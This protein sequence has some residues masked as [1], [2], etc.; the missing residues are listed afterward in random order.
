MSYYKEARYQMMI[1]SRKMVDAFNKADSVNASVDM[2]IAPPSAPSNPPEEDATYVISAEERVD[3]AFSQSLMM[4]EFLHDLPHDFEE[5]W[6][7]VPFPQ[8]SR[9]LLVAKGG[10][11]V[12]R[13]V[14]GTKMDTFQS[15]LP[16][17]SGFQTS[18]KSVHTLLDCIQID[19]LDRSNPD[20]APQIVYVVLDMLSW[21]GK[22]YYNSDTETR[23]WMKQWIDDTEGLAMVERRNC[24]TRND[25]LILTLP[26]Y[27]VLP[28]TLL[29]VT[30]N[31]IQLG[32]NMPAIQPNEAM[33]EPSGDDFS[34][35]LGPSSLSA[36]VDG[37]MFYFNEMDYVGAQ[38]PTMCLLPINDARK[39]A[40]ERSP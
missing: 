13:D 14:E 4:P 11:T 27:D 3:R 17:G 30:S 22:F 1:K 7:C 15:L 35:W 36:R 39:L 28:K 5:S 29:H 20:L 9:C 2:D 32:I 37:L 12:A 38:T 16:G 23:F 18:D 26:H 34:A 6:C 40:L 8:G 33:M 21:N 19:A 24:A 31:L 10:Q 25:R